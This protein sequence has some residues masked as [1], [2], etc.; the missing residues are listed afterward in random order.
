MSRILGL[1][2]ATIGFLIGAT[3]FWL[4]T[5]YT[6]GYEWAEREFDK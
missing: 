2:V 3:I 6:H 4:V 1:P 5:G